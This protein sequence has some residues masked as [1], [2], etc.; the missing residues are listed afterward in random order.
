MRHDDGDNDDV[1]HGGGGNGNDALPTD[2]DGYTNTGDL[3][4]RE[5]PAE[6]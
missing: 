5:E 4:Q 1:D 3:M 2:G 6:A